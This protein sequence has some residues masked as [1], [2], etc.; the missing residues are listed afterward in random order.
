M[1]RPSVT[2]LVSPS[3]S[4]MSDE[5]QLLFREARQRR[6]RRWLVAGMVVVAFVLVGT[7]AGFVASGGGSG[8]GPISPPISNA[9]PPTVGPIHP[10]TPGTTELVWF[11][12]GGRHLGTP[13][14]GTARVVP[15]PAPAATRPLHIR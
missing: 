14:Q 8:T 6:R 4:P 3:Q 15:Q 11:A 7:T 12:S 9:T 2:I 10:V 13:G 5:A 1:A